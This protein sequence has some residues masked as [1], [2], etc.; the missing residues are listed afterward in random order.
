MFELTVTY[1]KQGV[2]FGRLIGKF[3]AVR[4]QITILA[5]E[6]TAAKSIVINSK[7]KCRNLLFTSNPI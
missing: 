1:S 7:N 5:G 4:R 6:V 3:Q 2:Q